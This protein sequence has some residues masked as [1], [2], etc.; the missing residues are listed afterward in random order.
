MQYY[1]YKYFL[2]NE[3]SYVIDL[4]KRGFVKTLYAKPTNS[5]KKIKELLFEDLRIDK[6]EFYELDLVVMMKYTNLYNSTNLKILVKMFEGG[7]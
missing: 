7:K 2:K 5:V 4:S 3:Y 1:F 6:S